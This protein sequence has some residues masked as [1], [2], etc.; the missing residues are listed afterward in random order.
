MKLESDNFE[1]VPVCKLE[2]I[3]L[4]GNFDR[5]Q[6]FVLDDVLGIY[7]VDMAIY[8]SIASHM[9]SIFKA[10]GEESKLLFTRRKTVYVEVKRLKSFVTEN[11]VDLQSV[12]NELNES[13]KLN[14]LTQHCKCTDVEI[15]LF[16]KM[17][18]TSARVMFPFLCKLFSSD[19]KYQKLG[20]SF[21]NK[22]HECLIEEV[23]KL[24]LRNTIQY[25]AL[26]LCLVNNNKVSNENL[27]L[28]QL[29][30]DIYN[31]CGINQGTSDRT[32]TDVLSYMIGTYI[33]KS[34]SEYTLIHDFILEVVAYHY[35]K[36]Y[37]HQILRFMSSN[38]VAN[39]V[40]VCKQISNDDLYI[41]LNEDQYPM[42]A[43]RLYEDILSLGLYDVFTNS[44]LS[45]PQFMNVFIEIL[46]EKPYM[47]FKELF[48][49]EQV[50]FD[51]VVKTGIS[52]KSND[53]ITEW[54]EWFR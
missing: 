11:V 12:D 18:F 33:V 36:D 25:A 52:L 34:G 13:E 5:K 39:K 53:S 9:S 28:K 7:S 14:I 8:N 16:E 31:D 23:A 3:L 4:Y 42:F 43:N 1:V 30:S 47:E 2:E 20:T 6:V 29:K 26:V 24:Q 32:I 22:P 51:H 48:L 19:I 17:S 46:N 40:V 44:A 49:S 21:F 10:I 38:F 50:N 45:H 35:G 15:K 54:V 41:E 27:S 37:P